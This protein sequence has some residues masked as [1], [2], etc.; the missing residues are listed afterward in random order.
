MNTPATTEGTP[1]IAVTMVRTNRVPHPPTSFR[2]MAVKNANGTAIRVAR[3][4]SSNV[5][6]IA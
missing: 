4:T 2:K 1:L 6:T 5:P 3:P